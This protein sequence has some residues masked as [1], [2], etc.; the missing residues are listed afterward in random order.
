MCPDGSRLWNGHMGTRRLRVFRHPAD[1]C[2]LYLS[3]EQRDK[4]PFSHPFHVLVRCDWALVG[5]SCHPLLQWTAR[6]YQWT[7]CEVFVLRILSLALL[8]D[9]MHSMIF[10]YETM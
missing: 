6:F 8:W 4:K 5:I 7:V 3:D 1:L 2:V 9:I 10:C